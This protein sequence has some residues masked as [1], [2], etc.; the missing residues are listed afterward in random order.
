M[1][2]QIVENNRVDQFLD[3]TGLN[4]KVRTEGLQT[5]SGIIIPDKIGI[6][7]EDDST[8]LGIHSN[9]YV[10]YQNDQMMELLFKVSQQTGLDVHRGGLFGGGRKVFVQLKSNDLALGTDRIEGYVTGIN[11]FDGSTSLSFGPSSKTISCQ[12]TFFGVYKDLNSKVR[13]T[14][15]M[16]LKIDDICRQIEGVVEEEKNVFGSIVKMSETRFDDIIKDRVIKSLFNIEKNVNI[17]DI[18]AISS[19]TQNKLSRFY[20]DLNGEIQGKGDNLWGLFSGVTKYTTHS[21]GKGD[22]SENKM[23]GSYGNRE[24]QIF[25]ELVHLV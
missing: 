5:S 1:E 9:G 14:K 24:R 12:N 11:S 10:P 7:R 23:F 22:N 16:E 21:M 2:N 13:H 15:N 17:K 18:D 25:K 8:I 6:V 3:R 4:W 20:V 19:V